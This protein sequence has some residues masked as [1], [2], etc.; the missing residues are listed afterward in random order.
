MSNNQYQYN[1]YKEYVNAQIEANKR[2]I[3]NVWVQKNTIE[4]IKK[5]IPDAKTILCHGTR[6][7]AEQKYFKQFY[8]NAEV[9]GTEISNTANQFEDTVQWDFHDVNEDWLEKFDIV[10]SNS[11][12]HSF[13]PDK[14]FRAWKDQLSSVGTLII[15]LQ[16]RNQNIKKSDPC[17]MSLE[18]FDN[19]AQE[20]GM[21]I[22]DKVWLNE[23]TDILF[24]KVK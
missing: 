22:K 9:I 15:E 18:F 17:W 2:K 3:H 6:N 16:H 7:G 20:R 8:V 14:S 11:F 23:L 19:F 24:L 5:H 13:D 4:L 10:Y 21:F 12:D 1:S